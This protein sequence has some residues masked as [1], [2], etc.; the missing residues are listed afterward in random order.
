MIPDD[1]YIILGGKLTVA[2]KNVGT[3]TEQYKARFVALGKN[4]PDTVYHIH[5]APTVK[6]RS[7]LIQI[8]IGASNNDEAKSVDVDQAFT[9]STKPKR[10]I[11]LRP[12]K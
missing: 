9:Q 4:D 10:N 12:S 2:I 6:K 1:D 11:Y 5:Y 8:S 7:L 3:D